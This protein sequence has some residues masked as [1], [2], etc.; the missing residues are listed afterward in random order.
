MTLGNIV[1]KQ[2]LP[3]DMERY[4][5]NLKDDVSIIRFAMQDLKITELEMIVLEQIYNS[6]NGYNVLKP[7][8]SFVRPIK[9]NF[10]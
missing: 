4:L 2:K 8:S 9:Y 5:T 3:I 7:K 1:Q 10:N 6:E